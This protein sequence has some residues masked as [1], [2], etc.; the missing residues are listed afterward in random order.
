MGVGVAAQTTAG[1][2]KGTLKNGEPAY[3]CGLTTQNGIILARPKAASNGRKH[4]M[5]TGLAETKQHTAPNSPK[6]NLTNIMRLY[7]DTRERS[8]KST[9]PTTTT[10]ASGKPP[11]PSRRQPRC[12]TSNAIRTTPCRPCTTLQQAPCLKAPCAQ[13]LRRHRESVMSMYLLPSAL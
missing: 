13:M 6:R 4:P 10:E 11:A 9:A 8:N 7:P 5:R 12:Q 2:P 1:N 3:E